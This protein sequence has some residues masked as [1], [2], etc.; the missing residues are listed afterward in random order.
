LSGSNWGSDRELDHPRGFGRWP[1]SRL[2]ERYRERH[3]GTTQCLPAWEQNYSRT[4]R[5][6]WTVQTGMCRV[7]AHRK[8]SVRKVSKLPDSGTVRKTAGQSQDKERSDREGIIAGFRPQRGI[9]GAASRWFIDASIEGDRWRADTAG[10]T[11]GLFG[12]AA[13]RQ[14]SEAKKDGRISPLFP[15]GTTTDRGARPFRA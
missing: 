14:S 9:I 3:A 6:S 7:N 10:Q 5:T 8:R 1:R 11:R 12:Q 15:A 13:D 2:P 4:L